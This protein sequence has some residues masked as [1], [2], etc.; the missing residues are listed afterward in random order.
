MYG[1]LGCHPAPACVEASGLCKLELVAAYKDSPAPLG[2]Q[3]LHD[4][5]VVVGFDRIADDRLQ[6]LQRRL[7]CSVVGLDL[8]LAVVGSRS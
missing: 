7:V 8:G 1:A 3:Q 6:A 5:E 4:K 2:R